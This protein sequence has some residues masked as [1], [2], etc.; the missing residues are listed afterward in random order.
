MPLQRGPSPCT[1]IGSFTT[2]N[3]PAARRGV[4][5]SLVA[6]L[7][8]VSQWRGTDT[9]DDDL[10]VLAIEMRGQTGCAA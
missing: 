4:G 3:R 6:L 5:E 9:L 1:S 8:A 10:T 2:H 7:W